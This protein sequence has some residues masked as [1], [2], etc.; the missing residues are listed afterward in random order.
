MIHTQQNLLVYKKMP[1]DRFAALQMKYVDP[2][3][4]H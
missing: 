1:Q 2:L 4:L 3:G